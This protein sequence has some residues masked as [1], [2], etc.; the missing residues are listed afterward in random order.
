MAEETEQLTG[1]SDRAVYHVTPPRFI[2][3]ETFNMLDFSNKK[4]KKIQINEIKP[5]HNKMLSQISHLASTLPQ[6]PHCT[7]ICCVIS[8]IRGEVLP[9]FKYLHEGE[10]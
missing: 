7:K 8:G 6:K 4:Y 5:L 9:N 10:V 2:T 1:L 3:N